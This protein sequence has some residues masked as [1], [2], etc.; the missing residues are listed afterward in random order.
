MA[1]RAR[2]R[3]RGRRAGLRRA[4]F[5]AAFTGHTLGW[6]AAALALAATLPGA[7][8]L[9]V[10]PGLAMAALAATRTVGVSA[11]AGALGA[12][13][14]VPVRPRRLRVARRRRLDNHRGD[15]RA[16]RDHVRTAAWPRSRGESRSAASR[17][18]P[19][20]PSSAAV[21]P[22]QSAS[23]P[24]HASIA[25]VIDSDSGAARWQ[26]D[27]PPAEVRAAAA[28][29]AERRLRGPAPPEPPTS[30]PRR[31]SQSRRPRSAGRRPAAATRE[32]TLDVM[33][34]RRAPRLLIAWHSESDRSRDR[35]RLAAAAPGALARLRSRRAG[36]GSSCWARRRT[37]ESRCAAWRP[38]T[39]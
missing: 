35:R 3:G 25:Y 28:F 36:T 21:V 8:Y 7:A 22:R 13:A 6:N 38:P 23:H 12:A 4:S 26:L 34:T 32:I 29:E 18:R 39:R 9:A 10:V 19:C 11:N 37:V 14:I 31:A 16:R 24:R 2:R 33:S 17:W 5:D 30:R 20:W 15:G 1:A 27:D